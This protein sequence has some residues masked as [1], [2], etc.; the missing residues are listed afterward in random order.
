MK[1]P[2][3]AAAGRRGMKPARTM[4]TRSSFGFES[5]ACTWKRATAVRFWP[6]SLASARIRSSG[7]PRRL[8][9]SRGRGTALQAAFRWQWTP[10]PGGGLSAD[11]GRQITPVAWRVAARQWL[12]KNGLIKIRLAGNVSPNFWAICVRISDLAHF[13]TAVAACGNLIFIRHHAGP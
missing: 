11:G 1:N 8:P 9:G 5:F 10:G 13:L 3:T 12:V 4:L 7:G 2:K 6:S